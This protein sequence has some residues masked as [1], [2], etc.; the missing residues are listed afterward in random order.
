MAAAGYPAVGTVPLP[1]PPVALA[2]VG[3]ICPKA[4]GGSAAAGIIP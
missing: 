4:V 3:D 1:P 2:P